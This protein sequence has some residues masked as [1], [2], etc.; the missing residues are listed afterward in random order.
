MV[1]YLASLL[2]SV[3]AVEFWLNSDKKQA[4]CMKK[5]VDLSHCHDL[6]HE[7][8]KSGAKVRRKQKNAVLDY[9]STAK[10]SRRVRC[11]EG[12]MAH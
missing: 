11:A 10:I 12:G 7:Y 4:L 1:V 8:T 2:T 3:D 6:S 5:A 9:K